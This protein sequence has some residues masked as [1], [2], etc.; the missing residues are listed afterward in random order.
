MHLAA[1]ERLGHKYRSSVVPIFQRVQ[2]WERVRRVRRAIQFDDI[3]TRVRVAWPSAALPTATQVSVNR[4]S[5]L[6]RLENCA[7][8]GSNCPGGPT[9]SRPSVPQ[10]SSS[11][12]PGGVLR[13]RPRCTTPRCTTPHTALAVDV[14]HSKPPTRR[15]EHRNRQHGQRHQL[16][17]HETLPCPPR[18]PRR[19]GQL[20]LPQIRLGRHSPRWVRPHS[21]PAV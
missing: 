3:S 19:C 9:W 16:G 8:G 21:S 7:P 17:L 18:G 6:S 5:T 13:R 2:V 10:A 15:A 1:G 11:V 14:P 20:N 4:Q 12:P